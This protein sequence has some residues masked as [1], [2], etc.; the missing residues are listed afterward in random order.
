[1]ATA[2]FFGPI[3]DAAGGSE[4]ALPD[5][6]RTVADALDWLCGEAPALSQHLPRAKL[7]V[8]GELVGP[9]HPL[10]PG[11]ELSVLSPASGG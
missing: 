1:M 8:N 2:L 3:G 7:A 4:R 10:R 9:A 5:D 11:D 6:C